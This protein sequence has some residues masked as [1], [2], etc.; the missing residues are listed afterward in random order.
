[1]QVWHNYFVVI[2]RQTADRA[3]LI[4]DSSD[5]SQTPY[6]A[7]EPWT[8]AGNRGRLGRLATWHLSGGSVGPASRWAA[9]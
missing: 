5:F 7:A 9:T 3:A 8:R 1:V 4:S 2:G 6:E